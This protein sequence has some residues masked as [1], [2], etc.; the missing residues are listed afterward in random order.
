MIKLIGFFLV[1]VLVFWS[2]SWA[3]YPPRSYASPSSSSMMYISGYFFFSLE[4]NIMLGIA[5]FNGMYTTGSVLAVEDRGAE[6]MGR[7]DS[8]WV[9]RRAFRRPGQ[10]TVDRRSTASR[11]TH[12]LKSHRSGRCLDVRVVTTSPRPRG[13]FTSGARLSVT[14]GQDSRDVVIPRRSNHQRGPRRWFDPT[15]KPPDL[16]LSRLGQL[17]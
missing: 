1:L 7:F 4:Q 10:S 13:R 6:D 11:L 8:P 16:G 2:V 15:R 9:N 14:C 17:R 3:G 12:L 5:Y